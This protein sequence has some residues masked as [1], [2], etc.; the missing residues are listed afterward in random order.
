MA[1]QTLE[2]GATTGLGLTA[3]LFAIGSDTVV[4]T[5]SSVT[6]ATNRK[7]IYSAVFTDAPAA[8]YLL[9]VFLGS[10]G[11]ASYQYALT[12]E[13]ATFQPSTGGGGGDATLAKQ[14]EILGQ[15]AGGGAHEIEVTVERSTDNTAV[16]GARVSIVGTSI[17]ETTGT[18]GI[19]T[20]L[21]DNG[22]YEIRIL[23]PSGF[24]SP[25]DLN[26]TVSDDDEQETVEVVPN[27]VS[28]TGVGWLG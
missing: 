24:D 18:N 4:Q 5:A 19:A 11:I 21:V 12:L 27:F 17:A 9:I 10:D 26:V 20:L 7:G 2:F 3:K 28:A 22:T 1:T 8:D 6:E 13:T 14:N 23:P 15:F 25:E 16:S